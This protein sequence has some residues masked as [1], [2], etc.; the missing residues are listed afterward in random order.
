MD[1]AE[2]EDFL[3]RKLPDLDERLRQ[4]EIRHGP[5]VWLD[6]HDLLLAMAHRGSLP[7]RA[8]DLAPYLS[9]L[10]CK[11][12]EQQR[13]FAS[14]FQ[15]CMSDSGEERRIEFLPDGT[16]T[17]R[18]RAASWRQ[19]LARAQRLFGNSPFRLVAPA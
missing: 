10:L 12:P 4:Q 3:A 14:L 13:N 6:V 1:I 9:P 15:A 18:Q 8:A 5:D 17:G 11:S 7:E 19:R 16:E 2:L